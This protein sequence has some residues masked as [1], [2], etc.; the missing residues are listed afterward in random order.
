MAE[1]PYRQR[2]PPDFSPDFNHMR[3]DLDLNVRRPPSDPT[4]GGIVIY[5]AAI[6]G[7]CKG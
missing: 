3:G 5:S 2:L 6:V 4:F 1:P 7:E